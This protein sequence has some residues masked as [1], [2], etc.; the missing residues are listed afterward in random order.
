MSSETENPAFTCISG[1]LVLLQQ[2]KKVLNFKLK[3][4]FSQFH[5]YHR[6][7]WVGCDPQGS[8]SPTFKCNIVI[9][10]HLFWWDTR[11]DWLVGQRSFPHG[12]FLVSWDVCV[13]GWSG[14][15]WS[16]LSAGLDWVIFWNPSQ[17]CISKG[18][19]FLKRQFLCVSVSAVW[20]YPQDTDPYFC[21]GYQLTHC[22]SEN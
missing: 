2:C 7:F 4:H 8:L 3:V 22:S 16:H 17:S 11:T 21:T 1:P 20:F 9:F 18:F 10:E 12:K 14:S 13:P 19:W 6:I 15:I 5:S